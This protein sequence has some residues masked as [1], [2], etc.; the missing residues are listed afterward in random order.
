MTTYF[1]SD[2]TEMQV[3]SYISHGD[4]WHQQRGIEIAYEDTGPGKFE[5]NENPG[6][7][8]RL[9]DCTVDGWCDDQRG[10]VDEG[11]WYGLL[12]R[13]I[14]TEDDRGFFSYEK[15]QNEREAERVFRTI[16]P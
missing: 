13:F 8:S 1:P 2:L 6:L 10:S 12:G 11:G 16:E 15:F 14:V 4:G 7:A 3:A 9:Y 5:G